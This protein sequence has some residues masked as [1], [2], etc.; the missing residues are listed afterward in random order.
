MDLGD[1][2]REV[3][4]AIGVAPNLIMVISYCGYVAFLPAMIVAFVVF[5][6]LIPRNK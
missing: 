4:G 2:V 5:G 6:W 1:S 3:S